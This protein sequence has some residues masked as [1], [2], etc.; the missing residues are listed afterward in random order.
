MPE[1]LKKNF[2]DK[3]FE[4]LDIR[5]NKRYII[6]RLYCYGDLKAIKWLKSLYNKE[7]IYFIISTY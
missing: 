6:S 5:K 2:G 3:K 1:E 4:K 7:D